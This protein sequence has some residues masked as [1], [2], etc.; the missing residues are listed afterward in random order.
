MN[1]H[2][3]CL[4]NWKALHNIQTFEVLQKKN[5]K[6]IVKSKESIASL[7][8]P[9]Q[10]ARWAHVTEKPEKIKTKVLNKG[11][12]IEGIVWIPTG[13]N[14]EPISIEGHKAAWKKA[15]KKPKNNI[16]QRL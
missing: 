14:S 2:K 5:P 1:K 6:N 9:K 11:N 4:K 8:Q 7:N 12:S 13:G 16:N 10:T 15:Q 3:H